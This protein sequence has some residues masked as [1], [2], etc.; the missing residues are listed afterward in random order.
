MLVVIERS[1]LWLAAGRNI[2]N[3][4]A[5]LLLRYGRIKAS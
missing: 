4:I 2:D 1:L 3:L 5:G